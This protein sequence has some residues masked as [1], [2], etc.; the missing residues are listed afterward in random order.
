MAKTL[1]KNIVISI[2][3][4]EDNLAVHCLRLNVDQKLAVGDR[5]TVI[6]ELRN[7][8]GAIEF[9]RGCTYEKPA[10]ESVT[11][12]KVFGGLKALQAD[13]NAS[14]GPYA[15]T[16]EI[17]AVEKEPSK[18]PQN[19]TFI[20]GALVMFAVGLFYMF[21]S[22]LTF[23]NPSS[24]LIVSVLLSFGSAILFFLS[25]SFNEKPKMVLIFK[26]VAI[27]LA[28]GFVVYIHVFQTSEYYLNMLEKFKKAGLA[29]ARDLALSQMTMVVTLVLG[30]VSIVGQVANTVLVAVI[31]ED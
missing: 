29:G 5:I 11:T 13:E 30:Y 17:Q 16:G 1:Y 21:M 10:A 25:T 6:G 28:I 9:E 14:H 7:H 2:A 3:N 26:L 12:S 31:K 22:D 4:G 19:I 23:K 24:M 15:V 18:L 27:A 20:I 8:N